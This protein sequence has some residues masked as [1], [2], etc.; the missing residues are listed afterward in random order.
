MEGYDQESYKISIFHVIFNV[1]FDLRQQH[2]L[3]REACFAK[4]AASAYFAFYSYGSAANISILCWYK[5]IG[6]ASDRCLKTKNSGSNV[7]KM[8]H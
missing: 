8:S 2:L 3:P 7:I 1:S 5:D 6:L 4:H